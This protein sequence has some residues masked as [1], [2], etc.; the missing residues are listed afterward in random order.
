VNVDQNIDVRKNAIVLKMHD[1]GLVP[2][3]INNPVMEFDL[4]RP[5]GIKGEIR[6]LTSRIAYWTTHFWKRVGQ[7]ESRLTHCDHAVMVYDFC[8]GVVRCFDC[9]CQKT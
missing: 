8:N 5:G 9:G 1:R 7:P 6:R 4:R 2:A 3:A